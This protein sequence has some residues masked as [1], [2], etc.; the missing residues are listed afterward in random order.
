MPVDLAAVQADDALLGLIGSGHAP[1]DADD[2][3]TRVLAAWRHEVHAA[4]VRELVDT[5]T[6]LAVIRAA[7]ARQPTR[8]RN[9][10]SGSIA[11]AAA[12][13]VIAF[14]AV[15]LVAKS[16]QPGDHL[17]GVTQMLYREYAQSVETAAAVRTEL[18]EANTALQQG[19]PARARAAL[20][21]A[22][23]QLPA[24]GEDQGRTELTTR[25]RQLEQ[26]L[27]GPPDPASVTLPG[28]PI[29]IPPMPP[30]SGPRAG[31][32]PH[33]SGPSREEPATTPDS[34]DELPGNPSTTNSDQFLS[35]RHY[36]RHRYPQPGS[37]PNSGAQN[38]GAQNNGSHNRGPGAQDSG[39]AQDSESHGDGGSAGMDGSRG[40]ANNGGTTSGDISD[41][42]NG[43]VTPS[44]GPSPNSPPRRPGTGQVSGPR[45]PS[46]GFPGCDRPPPRPGYC[47]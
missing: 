8:R 15:G 2:E 47:G 38:N 46:E 30:S 3:L 17:W 27:N 7:A 45:P 1:S 9:P 14:S 39:G 20:R 24:V 33:P 6:A 12:V 13:L 43:H 22:Q 23:Q 11:A 32:P 10:V 44:P 26:K 18:N 25:H 31:Q 37:I 16:A 4:P 35:D 29:F 21:Q 34:S 36:P 19:D 5:S 42:P 40:N 28:P 41:R